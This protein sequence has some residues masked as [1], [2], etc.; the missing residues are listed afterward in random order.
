M[1]NLIKRLKGKKGIAFIAMY[2]V[3]TV[4]S[5]LSA[6]FVGRSLSQNM[7]VSV[8]KKQAR[9][10]NLAEAGLDKTINWLRSQASPP[11][12]NYSNPWNA[13]NAS[14]S[15]ITGTYSVRIQDLGAPGN[16]TE[17]RRYKVTATGTSE[18][19]NQTMTNYIQTDNYARYIW[20]TD[21]ETY[22]GANVWFW[23]QDTLNGPTH[24]NAH[25]NIYGDPTFLGEV[26]SADDYIRFY[27]N[28]FN[29]NSY[30]ITN[31]PY[32]EPT[33]AEGVVFDAEDLTMPTQALNLRT[34]STAAGGMRLTGNTT[35]VLL[36][37]GTMNV[38]NTA[39][40]W[41]RRNMALPTNGALFVAC[42]GGSCSSGASLNIT[43]V[44][45]G[46]LTAGAQRNIIIP[47]N[48]TYASDPR[49]NA[50]SDDTLGLLA[51]EDIIIKSNAAY[52]LQ[53]QAS[54]MALD[55]VFMLENWNTVAAKGNLTVYG[56]II[57]EERGPVGTFNGATGVKV[58][59]YSKNYSYDS[60]LLSSPP[61]FFPTTGDYITL[62]W[63]D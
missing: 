17:I 32:D 35:V 24:T 49:V 6:A 34:A 33:F 3:L 61:P 59:G 15:L 54:M 63:E 23:T 28:G 27:N 16:L 8:F 4:L 13:G 57:Q 40:N 46:R 53:I 43:G 48:L 26:S 58:S 2:M 19:I 56:G 37:N 25:L 36:A 30:N 41:T 51:E 42:S 29:F 52:D 44:L 12:G 21:R 50:S 39:Q 60:R 47:G 9:A 31:P 5:L 7:A 55:T 45:N 1:D 11:I 62:S 14:T 38:T 22:G 18:N 10:F 20:F